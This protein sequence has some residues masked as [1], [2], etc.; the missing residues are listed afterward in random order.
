MS[1]ATM[2]EHI[3]IGIP[4]QSLRFYVYDNYA[5]LMEI[6]RHNPRSL[7]EKTQ[8]IMALIRNDADVNDDN[9]QQ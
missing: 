2:I 5:L 1:C 6:T 3:M 7:Y 8:F 4:K 9:R